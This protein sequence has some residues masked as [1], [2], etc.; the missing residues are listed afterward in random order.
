MMGLKQIT[1]A[2]KGNVEIHLLR[3]GEGLGD[4]VRPLSPCWPGLL[5][6]LSHQGLGQYGVQQCGRGGFGESKD[7]GGCTGQTHMKL[8][9]VE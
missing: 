3:E 4:L 7:R 8:Q 6:S 9:W 1:A 5:D 2:D